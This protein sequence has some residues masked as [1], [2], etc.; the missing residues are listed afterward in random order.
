MFTNGKLILRGVSS[1]ASLQA[2]T[3]VE[4]TTNPSICRCKSNMMLEISSETLNVLDL[5]TSRITDVLNILREGKIPL[6]PYTKP[7]DCLRRRDKITKNINF[8]F[9]LIFES[10]VMN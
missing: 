9:S 1:E 4:S 7:S 6:K 3:I 10:K 2:I 5:S 8:S